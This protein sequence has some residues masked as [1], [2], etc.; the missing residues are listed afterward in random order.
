M[1]TDDIKSH[2]DYKAGYF[3]AIDDRPDTGYG[4]MEY[5][6]GR[7][8][9]FFARNAFLRAGFKQDSEDSFSLSMKL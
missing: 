6:A 4:S 9:G 7:S 8:A 1:T 3:D 2:P 5:V